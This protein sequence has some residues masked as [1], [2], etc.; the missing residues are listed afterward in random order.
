[1]TRRPFAWRKL[2]LRVFFA[3]FLFVPS[4]AQADVFRGLLQSSPD[5]LHIDTSQQNEDEWLVTFGDRQQN[6]LHDIWLKR[7]PHDQ[8]ILKSCREENLINVSAYQLTAWETIHPQDI[9]I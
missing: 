2:L 8:P 1:M 7:G 3:L 6:T 5:F 4:Y 9:G